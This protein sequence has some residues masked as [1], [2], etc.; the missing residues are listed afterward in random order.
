MDTGASHDQ[1]TDSR[2]SGEAFHRAPHLDSQS[3]DL[4]NSSGNQRRFC[5]VAVSHTVRNSGRQRNDILKR[6]SKFHAKHIRTGIHTEHFIH[7]HLLQILGRL[8]LLRPHYHAGRKSSP[9]LLRM[10]RSGQDCHVRLG[11]L[12]LNLLRK[13]H[14][15]TFFDSL[16]HIHDYLSV[17]DVRAHTAC[18][19]PRKRRRH[20]QYD[21]ILSL[22]RTFH[23]RRK[24]H[25]FGN[26]HPRQ[27]T[28]MLPL[29][30]QHLNFLFTDRP[31]R[32]LMSVLMKQKR[33]R[34]T[35]ASRSHNPYIRHI[36]TFLSLFT[37]SDTELVLRSG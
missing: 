30:R 23:I 35:P 17:R 34:R 6:A 14:Q 28:Y 7:E 10:A 4:R 29:L 26:L 32:N 21:K 18:R 25:I 8:F 3:R 2:K 31:H 11:N 24:Y 16:R 20:G 22:Q 33:Q 9:D 37:C 36:S 13:R 1:I 15:S 19:I 5:I 27:L 12:L